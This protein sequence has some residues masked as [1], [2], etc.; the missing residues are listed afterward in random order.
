MISSPLMLPTALNTVAL[1]K[2][3]V[4]L[5]WTVPLLWALRLALFSAPPALV[6]VSPVMAGATVPCSITLATWV[7]GSVP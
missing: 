1:V 2:V 6:T 3:S 5:C 4:Q 7:A